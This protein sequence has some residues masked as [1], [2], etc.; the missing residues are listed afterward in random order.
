LRIGSVGHPLP[1]TEVRLGPDNELLIRGPGVMAGYHQLDEAT[2]ESLSE[3]GWFHTGDIGTIDADGF[4]HVTDRKKDLFKTS[5]GKY[6]APQVIEARFKGLC[7]YASQFLVYGQG[8]TYCTGIV[9]LDPES[10]E[11]WAAEN[12]LPGLSYAELVASTPV[13]D[14]VQGYIDE[15]NGR[16]N[17]W[18]T[19]KEFILLDHDMTVETGEVTPSLKLKRKA[20][21]ESYADQ[22]DALYT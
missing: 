3:D 19:I 12:N 20:V 9:A 22:L 8:R 13:R 10:I 21:E 16:L 1:G 6:V 11:R 14:M 4:V 15:L 7:P 2:E 5:G 17:R 18:E